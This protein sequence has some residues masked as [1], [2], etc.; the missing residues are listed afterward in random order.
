MFY[1]DADF[2]YTYLDADFA[3]VFS[4]DADYADFAE[5]EEELCTN[6]RN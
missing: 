4:L 3:E 2:I 5:K 1:L 6:T